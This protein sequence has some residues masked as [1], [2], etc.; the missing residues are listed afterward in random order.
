MF[1]LKICFGNL[2]VR[3]GGNFSPSSQYSKGVN[4]S[5]DVGGR[6]DVG[7]QEGWAEVFPGGAPI[8]MC[9]TQGVRK[10]FM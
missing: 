6:W 2:K 7:G 9:I 4:H 1:T 8:V 10:F 3:G 5:N